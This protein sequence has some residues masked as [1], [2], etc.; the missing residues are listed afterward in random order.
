MVEGSTGAPLPGRPRDELQHAVQF[1][2]DRLRRQPDDANTLA[3]KPRRPPSIMGYPV[4]VI[5]PLA[6][7]LDREPDL[8]A[9]KVE[10]EGADRVLTSEF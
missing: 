1:R 8:R 4:E 3:V 7:H 9:V 5:V 2:P 6:V 10:D